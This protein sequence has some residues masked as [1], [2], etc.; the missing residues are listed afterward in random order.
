MNYERVY[1]MTPSTFTLTLTDLETGFSHVKGTE[2]VAGLLWCAVAML[3]GCVLCGVWYYRRRLLKKLCSI[4][5]FFAVF[6]YLLMLFYALLLMEQYSATLWP[7]W[8]AFMPL[9]VL[10]MMLLIRRN[11][12]NQMRS[13]KR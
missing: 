13:S 12:S 1:S 5:I 9:I 11:V 8:A 2:S 3:A 6:Y 7:N 4:T 10:E